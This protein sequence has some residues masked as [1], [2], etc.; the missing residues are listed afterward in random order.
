MSEAQRPFVGIGII[1]RKDGKILIGERLSSHGAGTFQIPGGHLEFGE[2]FEACAEREVREETGVTVKVVDLI[3]IHNHI[4]YD[5][6]YVTV[7]MLADW[8]EGEITNPEREHSSNWQW[9]DPKH[10]PENMFP[11]SKENIDNWL[12]GT[13]YNS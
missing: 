12:A 7:G 9:L 3:A 5:K 1:V 4:K 8:V 11:H 6:H 2:T 10:L 13:I